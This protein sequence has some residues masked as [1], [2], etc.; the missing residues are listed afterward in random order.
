M[1]R[2]A[3][4]RT[5]VKAVGVIAAGIALAACAAGQAGKAKP[6][7]FLGDYSRLGKGGEGQALLVYVDPNARFSSYRKM[8]IDPVTIWRNAD[9]KDIAPNE[10]Q[11]LIDDLDDVLRMTLD[12][13][14]QLVKEPG[15]DV[16]RLRVAITEAEGSWRVIDGRLGDE[17]DPDLRAVT[18]KEPSEETKSFVGKAGVEAE[19]LDSASGTRLAA[20]IDRRVGARTLK[21][22]KNAWSDVEHAFRYWA[23]RLRDRLAELRKRS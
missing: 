23:D 19:I 22:E 3:G 9:T 21:P 7:G 8:I 2:R 18:P 11:D 6:S 17:L 10:A 1:G 12:D 4:V 16:L 13:D 20:A 14:Y 15:P 5:W